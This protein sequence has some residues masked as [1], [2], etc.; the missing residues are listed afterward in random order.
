M[1]ERLTLK[2]NFVTSILGLLGGL[3]GFF[4]FMPLANYHAGKVSKISSNYNTLLQIITIWRIF[5]FSVGIW[6]LLSSI[7]TAFNLHIHY[8]DL[9]ERLEKFYT[10]D[11]LKFTGF[12]GIF[13]TFV[14]FIG[15]LYNL[16]E[17]H[18]AKL[19]FF[20][21]CRDLFGDFTSQ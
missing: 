15:K 4:T 14:G 18:Y 20:F 13:M 3:G 1:V 6:S 5:F 8:M 17:I 12:L 21:S 2:I 7:M 11:R 16:F 10:K 9:R 19:H